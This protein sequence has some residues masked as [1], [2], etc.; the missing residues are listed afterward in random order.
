MGSNKGLSSVAQEAEAAAE[1]ILSSRLIAPQPCSG[2]PPQVAEAAA[3]WLGLIGGLGGAGEGA[4]GGRGG[5]TRGWRETTATSVAGVRVLDRSG[6][7]QV[8]NISSMGRGGEGGK[9]A[10]TCSQEQERRGSEDRWLQMSLGVGGGR[11]G[12]GRRPRLDID[13]NF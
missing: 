1:M 10:I 8:V 6:V 9:D 13:L 5:S 2:C 4:G 3:R 12:D 11:S 7:R